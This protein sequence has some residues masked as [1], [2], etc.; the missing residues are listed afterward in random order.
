MWFKWYII[1]KSFFSIKVISTFFNLLFKLNA[2]WYHLSYSTAF[3]FTECHVL[4]SPNAILNIF[5][6]T[7]KN[8]PGNGGFGSTPFSLNLE[9]SNIQWFGLFLSNFT[10]NSTDILLT[11]KCF[12]FVI[13][14]FREFKNYNLSKSSV[15]SLT[16]TL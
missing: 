1:F 10:C 3:V 6:P 4:P 2:T 11:F 15:L 8:H 14:F 5:P 9:D 16:I 12:H 7:C 13:T